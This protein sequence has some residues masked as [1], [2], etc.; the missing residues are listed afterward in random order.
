MD[1]REVHK[2]AMQEE[3]DLLRFRKGNNSKV[4]SL[5]SSNSS[6]ATN[7]SLAS[8]STKKLPDFLQMI[9]S[10]KI[11]LRILTIRY[12]KRL[13]IETRRVKFWM[14]ERVREVA[15]HKVHI[16]KE[17]FPRD[18]L[19]DSQLKLWVH[20]MLR[21]IGKVKLVMPDQEDQELLKEDQRH[22]LPPLS[23]QKRQ[24]L[25]CTQKSMRMKNGLPFK[26]S[27][28]FSTMKSRNKPF[29]EKQ[30]GNA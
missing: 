19:V 2:W 1:L 13:I 11:I 9:G 7:L 3:R 12:R 24:P 15:G 5:T 4:C 29:L 26:N 10:P 16:R 14:I 17:E 18:L 8:S 22:M 28:L 20:W 27:T 21:M 30:K 6:M 25:S 23:P